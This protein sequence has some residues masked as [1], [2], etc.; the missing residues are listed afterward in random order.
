M[1]YIFLQKYEFL[2]NPFFSKAAGNMKNKMK[3]KTK[4]KQSM[5]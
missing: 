4:C 1:F 3:K 5:I 2:C